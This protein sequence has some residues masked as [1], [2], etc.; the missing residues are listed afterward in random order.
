MQLII[1]SAVKTVFLSAAV[2][3]LQNCAMTE[4][5]ETSGGE[6][7][8]IAEGPWC[9]FNVS[10]NGR[11][12]QHLGDTSPY[13]EN[14]GS[15]LPTHQRRSL[16]VNLKTGEN[17]IPQPDDEVKEL[18]KKGLGPD[19]AGCFSPDQKT[20]YYSQ[21]VLNQDE[22]KRTEQM[23]AGDTDSRTRLS[24]PGRSLDKYFYAID[25]TKVPLTIVKTNQKEC[26]ERAEPA[27]PELQAEQISDKE[28]R[29][30]SSQGQLL[31]THHPRGLLS[32]RITVFDPSGDQWKHSF[33]PSP[34]GNRIAYFVHEQGLA[35]FSAPTP[36][37]WLDISGGDQG[38]ENFLAASVYS[39]QWGDEKNLYACTSHSE[40]GRVIARWKL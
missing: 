17:H 26:A 14:E 27:R 31:A 6:I 32:G 29:I 15:S 8:A 24:V 11:W 4:D 25:L 16:F 39:F 23:V 12:L 34:G 38:E 3:V 19:A 1:R 5:P 30:Q 13:F 7:I 22:P 18:I 35:G 36:G 10:Q 33:S 20:V 28:I 40:Y 21:T 9:E 37:Y 2:L